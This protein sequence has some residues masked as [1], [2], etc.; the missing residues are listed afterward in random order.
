MWDLH[1]SSKLVFFVQIDDSLYKQ[2][3]VTKK[4]DG[5]HPVSNCHQRKQTL[6]GVIGQLS[7]SGWKPSTQR[8]WVWTITWLCK[9]TRT[10]SLTTAGVILP[11]ANHLMSGS[12][13][14]LR[15]GRTAARLAVPYWLS[16]FV[17]CMR[18]L[19]SFQAL[20]YP[21][22]KTNTAAICCLRAAAG[23]DLNR[24]PSTCNSSK[25]LLYCNV[26]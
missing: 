16:D 1:K 12:N 24:Q 13:L 9:Y 25:K 10:Q 2:P 26:C 11:H 21:S 6:L 20:I 15:A 14:F 7:K 5:S 22:T 8:K 3:R 23:A 19:P 17:T 18:L 4:N